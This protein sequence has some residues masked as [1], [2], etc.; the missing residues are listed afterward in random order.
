M[1]FN[2]TPADLRKLKPALVETRAQLFANVLNESFVQGDITTA[3]RCC[4]FMAQVMVETGGLSSLVES[5]SYRDAR[6]LDELFAN[7]QGIDHA[8]RLIALGAQAIGNTIYAN[9]LGNGGI[10]SGDGYRFRGRGFLQ[11]TGR[12]N[13]RNIGKIAEMPLERQ[14][15]QMGEPV[16]AARA[17]GIYWRT[18]NINGAADA[19][20]VSTVT[21]LVNGTARLH[22]KERRDWLAKAKS[23]WAN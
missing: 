20:D 3:R 13:Y 11:V 9:K 5:T 1:A 23:V 14:P 19:D 8:Q 15:E 12:D 22:L 2:I 6:R 10:D 4:H 7:V 17:A 16:P 21:L 18:R